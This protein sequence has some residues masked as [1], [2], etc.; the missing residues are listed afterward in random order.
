MKT[1]VVSHVTPVMSL[2]VV[3]VSLGPVR[4]IRP[5]VVVM[6]CVAEVSQCNISNVL[7]GPFCMIRIMIYAFYFI[8]V[9]SV[10]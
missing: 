2:L 4:V 9:L 8:S 5:G 6:P 1:L 10:T 7:Y 3:V